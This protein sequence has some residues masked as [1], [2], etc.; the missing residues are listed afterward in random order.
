V[1][2]TTVPARKWR[3]QKSFLTPRLSLSARR[4]VALSFAVTGG[5]LPRASV[6]VDQAPADETDALAALA[7]EYRSRSARFV[8]ARAA[9]IPEAG[10][11]DDAR[12][13]AADIVLWLHSRIYFTTMRALVGKAVTAAGRRDRG[14]EASLCAGETL[15]A[16]DRSR[17]ALQQLPDVDDER[18]VL[19]ALLDAIALGIGRRFPG[20]GGQKVTLGRVQEK[21]PL[22]F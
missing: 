5:M 14:E 16:I 4:N 21:S 8:S 19:V 13:A 3:R 6:A 18:R 7:L 17:A 9:A 2:L 10:T 15:V 1:D 20:A 11:L 12:S 22:H